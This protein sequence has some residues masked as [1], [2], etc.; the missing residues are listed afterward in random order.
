MGYCLYQLLLREVNSLKEKLACARVAPVSF[1]QLGLLFPKQIRVD[2][3]VVYPVPRSHTVHAP[4]LAN[5]DLNFALKKFDAPLDQE[6]LA[7]GLSE[8]SIDSEHFRRWRDRDLV[9]LPAP[10]LLCLAHK[11]RGFGCERHSFVDRAVEF[12]AG[13]AEEFAISR[14][15]S[16]PEVGGCRSP[17]QTRSRWPRSG[18]VQASL[19]SP[20]RIDVYASPAG[21]SSC[22]S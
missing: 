13:N 8:L 16:R 12:S 7:A 4:V 11:G 22:R 17:G 20:W 6:F 5:R 10:Q 1:I 14:F 21:S 18:R 9:G 2:R 15:A 3:P 19:M